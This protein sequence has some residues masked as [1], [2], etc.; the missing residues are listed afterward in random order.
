[1]SGISI[2][3]SIASLNQPFKQALQTVASMRVHGIEIDARNDIRPSDLSVSGVRQLRKMLN[4]LNLTVKSV[5]FPTR[6]GYD[7]IEDLDRRVSATK[8]AMKMAVEL[9]CNVLVNSIGTIP[10]EISETVN[11]QA[12]AMRE[13]LTDIGRYS[14][15]Y[16]CF[17]ACESGAEP[18]P[19]LSKFISTLPEE[20]IFIAL[21]PANLINAGHSIDDLA[22]CANQVRV[23]YAFD[24]VPDRSHRGHGMRVPLGQ[25]I[26]DIPQ[27]VG[28]L[29]DSR[30]N[31][32]FIVNGQGM[33]KPVDACQQ[34]VE[35]LQ[36]M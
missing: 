31:L 20:S 7:C 4:D 25:G 34:A 22:S 9:G 11:E 8:D 19:T 3:V 1:V 29:Q 24:V 28:T 30:I 16:G 33:A 36:R 23:A 18:L 26:V 27:L 5:R 14:Y 6:R 32:A 15:H 17:L 2:A 35:F 10:D 12:L 13:A 21:N